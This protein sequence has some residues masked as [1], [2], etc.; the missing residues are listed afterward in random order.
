MTIV[1][2]STETSRFDHEYYVEKHMK[3]A[4]KI[5]GDEVKSMSLTKGVA[6]LPEGKP[7]YHAIL[8]V[9]FHS[10]EAMG[11]ALSSPEMPKLAD[12]VVNYTDATPVA[13]VSE[14]L[15]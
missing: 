5:F 11:R 9:V 14:V 12:D 1:Y 2:G 13:Q 4:A 6:A 15:G 10:A 3:L 8:N 7:P